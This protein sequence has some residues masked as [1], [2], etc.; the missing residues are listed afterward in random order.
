[1]VMKKL[2]QIK[3]NKFYKLLDKLSDP[4]FLVACYEEIKGKK[5]NMTQGSDNYTIDG[6]NWDWFVKTAVSIRKGT[7]NFT[8][9]RIIEI[10]QANG[11]TKPLGIC[12]PRDNI[13]QKALHA[14]LEAIY[15]PVFLEYSH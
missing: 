11:K 9:A 5:G 8:P 15:E 4:F 6:L 14:I 3:G 1:M 13:V 10:P 12:Y 7:F 2:T